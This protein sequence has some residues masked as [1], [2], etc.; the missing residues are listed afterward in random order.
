MTAMIGSIEALL[1][2]LNSVALTEEDVIDS[3]ITLSNGLYEIGLSTSFQHY[4]FYVDA[5]TSEVLGINAEPIVCLRSD[6]DE[7][8]NYAA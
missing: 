5:A 3:D 7:V 8:V 2:A 6:E 1:A 4:D